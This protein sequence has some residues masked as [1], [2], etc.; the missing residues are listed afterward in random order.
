MK[1]RAL[2]KGYKILFPLRDANFLSSLP[3]IE[4][5]FMFNTKQLDIGLLPTWRGLN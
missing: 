5:L 2:H 4:H 3:P 1:I